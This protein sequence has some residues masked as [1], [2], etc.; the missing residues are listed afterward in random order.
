MGNA[1]IVPIVRRI[2]EYLYK[3]HIECA[4]SESN[5]ERRDRAKVEVI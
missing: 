3:A 4:A 1:L 2:G 5:A